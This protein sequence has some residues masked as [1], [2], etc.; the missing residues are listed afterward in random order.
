MMGATMAVWMSSAHGLR[1]DLLPGCPWE[2]R[3]QRAV[4]RPAPQPPSPHGWQRRR[5]GCGGCA[6]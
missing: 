3:G 6:C 4:P 5:S 1:C 2:S